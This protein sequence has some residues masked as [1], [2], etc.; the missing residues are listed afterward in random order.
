MV[1]NVNNSY[2]T[3]AD[4]NKP[5]SWTDTARFYGYIKEKLPNAEFNVTLTH[6]PDGST[7]P[8]NCT[9]IA[10]MTGRIRGRNIKVSIKDKVVVAISMESASKSSGSIVYRLTD[11]PT[12]Q[13]DISKK[14]L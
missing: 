4:V 1:F 11:R 10:K 3:S 13:S 9:I 5:L 2:D 14:V 12:P 8:D 7:M 6:A